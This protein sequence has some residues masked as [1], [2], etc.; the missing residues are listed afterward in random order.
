MCGYSH[1]PSGTFNWTRHRGSTDS[2]DTGPPYDHT[3]FT[4]AGIKIH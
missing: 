3:T 1:D 4:S 2:F